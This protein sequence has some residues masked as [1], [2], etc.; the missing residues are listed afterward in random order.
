ML[1][2]KRVKQLFLSFWNAIEMELHSKINLTE[3]YKQE[4]SPIHTVLFKTKVTNSPVLHVTFIQFHRI[5]KTFC[6]F[7]LFGASTVQ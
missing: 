6:D 7:D 2:S 4:Q 3:F 1:S 5:L